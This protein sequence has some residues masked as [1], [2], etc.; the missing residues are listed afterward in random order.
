MLRKGKKKQ[1]PVFS[2]LKEI[3]LKSN[4][5]AE[6]VETAPFE[7]STISAET[8]VT[9]ASPSGILNR[10][11]QE[12]EDSPHSISAVQM[13]E[14]PVFENARAKDL[15][16]LFENSFVF[17]HPGT[18]LMGSVEYE[19]GR[20]NGEVLHEVTLTKGFYM[21]TTPVTQSQWRSV[22]GTN[23]SRFIEGGD[24]CPVE[25]V[26]WHA[27]LDFIRILNRMGE[28]IYRL[29]TEAEWEYACRAGSSESCFTGMIMEFFCGHDPCLH[30]V[31]WYCGNS[32]RKTHPVALKN[33]NDWGLYDMHGNVFEWCQDWYGSYS[34]EKS[35]DPIMS[36]PGPGR[37]IR[38]GSWFANAKNCRSAA[39]LYWSPQS[40][41]D[42]IGFRL[43]KESG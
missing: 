17:I 2:A 43:V 36:L 42:F 21:Q 24:E 22:M 6:E 37:V 10:L 25:N 9:G 12:V 26:T 41:S 20:D 35:L 13:R 14:E 19:V 1:S 30:A 16:S 39:R 3:D 32:D 29:P 27:C 34:S 11:E 8:P 23:P 40:K 15:P 18:F 31:G 33:A 4:H 28:T 38:G 7:E 5:I